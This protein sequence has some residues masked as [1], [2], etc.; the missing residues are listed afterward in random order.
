MKSTRAPVS[1][2][3]ISFNEEKNIE[4]CLESLAWADEIVV[5]DSESTDR[6]QELVRAPGRSWSG[7]TRLLVRKWDG[8]RNQRNF[9]L[10]TATHDWI[11]A[12]DSDE[13]CSKELAEKIQSV[14]AGGAGCKYFKVKRVEY[15]LGKEIHYGIWNPS[16]QDR[17]F[18]RPGVEYV[19]EIHEYPK[20]PGTSEQ[21]HEPI[22]HSPD[23][24]ISKILTKMNQYTTIEAQD[25]FDAGM[26]T[27]TF[28]IYFAA[29]AMFFKNFFYYKAY[30]DG[31]HGFIISIL[32]GISRSVRHMKIWE[33][34]ER[35]RRSKG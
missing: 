35:E 4:R 27:N 8:F 32:E 30:R 20:Y 10:R 23:V 3:V 6:T 18:F 1:A 21:I 2:I 12:L 34:Q 7:K 19:N 24:T 14:L 31:Y 29:F 26:R 11:F 16:Y 13:A 9:A 22:Y 17:F 15:F 28:R 25:R 5:V 33:L